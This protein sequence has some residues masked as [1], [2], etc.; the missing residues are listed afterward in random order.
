MPYFNKDTVNILFIHIPKT[1][2]TAVEY[3]LS[4]TNNIPLSKST[5]YFF[6]KTFSHVSL[7]HQTLSTILEN[8]STFNI[9]LSQLM[10]FTVVRNPYTRLISD[11]FFNKLITETE[12][13]CT[14]TKTIKTYLQRFVQN[15]TALDNHIRPQV[16]FLLVNGKIDPSIHILRQET[17]SSDMERLG[18]MN[19]PRQTESNNYY[20]LL[21]FEAVSLINTVYKED[22]VQFGY[23]MIK[24]EKELHKKRNPSE[25]NITPNQ[26]RI[27]RI[28]RSSSIFFPHK[29]PQ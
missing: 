1:G 27:A 16:Q 28:T 14:I 13:A 9:K 10:I 7:Q 3:Y 2:G 12:D 17:L 5:L 4:R 24:T 23:D 8:H 18:F 22:F 21:S 19:F 25:Q 11:L 6:D 20:N 15:E 29:Y 26:P